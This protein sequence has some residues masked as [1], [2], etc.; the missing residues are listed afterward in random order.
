MAW[1]LTTRPQHLTKPPH[2]TVILLL[3][4]FSRW[5]N[6]YFR[7]GGGGGGWYSSYLQFI[8]FYLCKI[9]IDSSKLYC[10]GPVPVSGDPDVVQSCVCMVTGSR[11]PDRASVTTEERKVLEQSGKAEMSFS[12]NSNTAK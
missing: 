6:Y 4:S 7:K 2:L 5:E 9:E 11:G 10:T 8:I 12:F 1:T 3:H